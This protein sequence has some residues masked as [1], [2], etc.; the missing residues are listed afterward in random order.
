MR[1][2]R[3]ILAASLATAVGCGDD[4]GGMDSGTRDAGV[5]P[6]AGRSD[7]G[8]T[9]DAGTMDGSTMDAGDPVTAADFVAALQRGLTE[10]CACFFSDDGYTTAEE[11]V[12]DQSPS[13]TEKACFMAAFDAAD[14]QETFACLTTVANDYADCLA[15]AACDST[16]A[17]SCGMTQEDAADACPGMTTE[18]QDAFD[19]AFDA[20]ASEMVVGPAGTCPD[21]SATSMM[22]GAEVFAGSTLLKGDDAHGSCSEGTGAPDLQFQWTAPT[23][24]TY[25][26]DTFGSSFDT[27]LYVLDGCGGTELSCND[28][29]DGDD[30]NLQSQLMLE[31]TEGTEYILVVDGYSST[32]A[33]DFVVNI[34]PPAG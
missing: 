34:T 20:C 32:D 17:M 19:A 33:G 10:E 13:T 16:T 12:A 31:A 14:A 23:T 29:A 6:D 11:C 9:M 4:D 15:A 18:Q 5:T 27:V 25:V 22:T 26:I 24:G 1:L 7:S 2:L 8:G 30:T 21:S 3:W 28:D